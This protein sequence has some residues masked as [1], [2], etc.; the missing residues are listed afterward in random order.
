MNSETHHFS[1]GGVY[2]GLFVMVDRET[3]TIWNHVTGEAVHGPL[4]GADLATRNL[5]Q[6]TVGQALA[7]DTEMRVAISERPYVK[8]RFSPGNPTQTIPDA[9]IPTLGTEDAR[10]PRMDIGLGVWA[11]GHSRYYPMETL[12]AN[13]NAFIDTF[14]GRQVLI[15]IQP[16]SA[17][18]AALFVDAASVVW[19][20][21]EVR[22]DTGVVGEG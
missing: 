11:D 5:L 7:M 2:D 18:P 16:E 4:T 3:E 20:Q 8:S 15:Y 17:T 9:F 12:R 1:V 13:G 22:L 10:R 21:E 14:S 6:M 19:S